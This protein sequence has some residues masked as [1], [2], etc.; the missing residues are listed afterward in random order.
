M[1]RLSDDLQADRFGPQPICL[2]NRVYT[3][4]KPESVLT[5]ADGRY[6]FAVYSGAYTLVSVAPGYVSTV[7]PQVEAQSNLTTTQDLTLWPFF[8]QYLPL[9]FG[10]G[11]AGD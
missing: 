7:L 10:A 11:S 9:T 5:G 4:R 1:S 2:G 8:Y 3:R 6:G